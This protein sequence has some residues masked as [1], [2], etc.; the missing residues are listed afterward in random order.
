[1]YAV[2]YQTYNQK[3]ERMSKKN[4]VKPTSEGKAEAKTEAPAEK[5]AE[6]KK[7]KEQKWT[8]ARVF[9]ELAPK[10]HKDKDALAQAII[11]FLSEKG[12]TQNIKERAIK[13][14]NVL[15]QVN[16][17]CRDINGAKTRGWW[18]KWE[19][20]EAEDTFKAEEKAQA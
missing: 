20:K 3:V 5:K 12:I 8:I 14:E 15:S 11:D 19:V 18:T 9:R 1:M 17:I 7:P 10:G 13:K 6:E 4:N 16:A 2:A